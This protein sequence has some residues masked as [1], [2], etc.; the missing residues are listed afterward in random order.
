MIDQTSP[1]PFDDIRALVASG[2]APDREAE[3][4]ARARD[5]QLT[6]PAGSL[7]RLEEIAAFVAA[8]QARAE[9]EILSPTVAVFAANHGVAERGVSAYPA[10]VT[11]QMVENFRRSGAAINQICLAND[12]ALRVFELALER[13]TGD[14]VETDAFESERECAAT[15][16]YGMEAIAGQVDLLCVG[17]MGIANTTVAAAL[18]HA[19]F[20][21]KAEDWV[22]GGTGVE[23]EAFAL[24]VQAVEQAVRRIEGER[25]PLV[26]LQRLGGREIA[27]IV[28]AIVAARHQRIPVIVDGFVTTAAAAVLYAMDPDAI[29]HCLFGHMSAEKAHRAALTELEA[30]PLLDLGMR[31]GEGTGAAL[32]AGLVR[33]AIQVHRGMAT[34]A[35][36]GVAGPGA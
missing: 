1:Q 10:A 35:D 34:F 33:A 31:L 23:G 26:I 28:G 19:L 2:P 11:A 30:T 29:A 25:D 21:G 9:P 22:G 15:I 4:A 13:P 36:A 16:A 32:A 24:K 12:M 8:W 3:A 27:A 7:G 14:I 5:A 18:F 20:G 17:E 6:K